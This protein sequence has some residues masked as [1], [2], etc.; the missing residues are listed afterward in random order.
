MKLKLFYLLLICFALQS[1][2]NPPVQYK[3]K[4]Y[5]ISKNNI[6]TYCEILENNI[7]DYSCA[8]YFKQTYEQKDGEEKIII[9]LDTDYLTLV[10]QTEKRDNKEIYDLYEHLLKEL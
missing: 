2:L 10:Y 7:P 9:K 6:K 3:E 4:N 8:K 1:C 5:P